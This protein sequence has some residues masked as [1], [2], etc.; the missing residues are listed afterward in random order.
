MLHFIDLISWWLL[1]LWNHKCKFLRSNIVLLAILV[2]QIG[3]CR[4]WTR[5]TENSP[6]PSS[7]LSLEQVILTLQHI[8]VSYLHEEERGHKKMFSPPVVS[9]SYQKSFL[10][11]TFPCFRAIPTISHLSEQEHLGALS[12]AVCGEQTKNRSVEDPMINC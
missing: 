6:S 4:S 7:P 2:M 3:R 11:S 10:M 9:V 12:K 1:L 8:C 5:H